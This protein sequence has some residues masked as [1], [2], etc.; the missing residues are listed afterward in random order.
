MT[1]A[2]PTGHG[3]DAPRMSSCAATAAAAAVAADDKHWR[4]SSESYWSDAAVQCGG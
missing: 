4:L 3:C 1:L 2:L